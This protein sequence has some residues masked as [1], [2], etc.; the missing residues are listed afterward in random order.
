M[1]VHP[2]GVNHLAIATRDIKAQIEFFTDVLGCE[3]KALYW[4]HGAEGAMHAFLELNPTSY[5]AFVHHPDNPGK[6]EWGLTH[7]ATPTSPVTA[8]AMQHVAFDLDSVEDLLTLRDRIRSRG[9]MAIGPVDHGFCRS[10]YFGGPEGL[11]LE[12]TAGEAIDDRAWIDPEVV[13]L[14][15]IDEAELARYRQ[16]ADY[17][18]PAEALPQPALDRTK[19][20]L[21]FPDEI[22]GF[23]ATATDEQLRELLSDTEPPVKVEN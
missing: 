9:I 12:V 5:I 20:H 19:P 16:P 1:T 14:A 2:R 13:A 15:G 21:N 18:R 23:L 4:M 3:L 6:T 22:Y 7:A 11:V 10:V 17:R 8:G